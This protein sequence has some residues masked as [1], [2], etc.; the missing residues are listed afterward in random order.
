MEQVQKLQ[1]EMAEAT[2]KAGDPDAPMKIKQ[3]EEEI[4]TMRKKCEDAA[5]AMRKKCEDAAE[6]GANFMRIMPPQFHSSLLGHIYIPN[7]THM[8]R[9]IIPCYE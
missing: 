4:A 8:T 7:V 6:A 2:S 3:L 9:I 1:D 5:E